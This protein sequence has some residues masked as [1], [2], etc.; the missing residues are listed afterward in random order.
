MQSTGVLNLGI[1]LTGVKEKCGVHLSYMYLA[2]T[3]AFTFPLFHPRPSVSNRRRALTRSR[4][5]ARLQAAVATNATAA[6]PCTLHT[7]C[8]IH[9]A[10][11]KPPLMRPRRSTLSPLSPCA[12]V[13][14]H[15][16]ACHSRTPTP[17]RSLRRP[18]ALARAALTP[19]AH[20]VFEFLPELLF[21]LLSRRVCVPTHPRHRQSRWVARRGRGRKSWSRSPSASGLA[22]RERGREGRDGGQGRQG[23]GVR[24]CSP[25][26]DQRAASQGQGQRSRYGQ[27]QRCQGHQSHDRGSTRVRSFTFSYRFRSRFRGKAV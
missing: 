18:P 10:N 14:L 22:Q 15:A 24:P 20:R 9:A 1:G 3:A 5:T 26:R 17:Q 7:P 21:A 27:S 25:V 13:R 8:A 12:A 2:R 19:S 23:A 6:A 16:T 11:A 4:A